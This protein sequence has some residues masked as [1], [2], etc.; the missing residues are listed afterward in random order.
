MEYIFS[1][2]NGIEFGNSFTNNNAHL[3]GCD[4]DVQ[5]LLEEIMNQN[6]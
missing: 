2:L 5:L 3:V 6:R 4:R 1:F